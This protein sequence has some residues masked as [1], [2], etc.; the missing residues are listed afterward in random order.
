MPDLCLYFQVHQPYRLRP[1]SFFE[2]RR[3]ANYF[4]DSLNRD[5]MQRVA[6]RCYIP[7]GKSVLQAI[8]A[9]G[10]QLKLT[11]SITGTAIEQMREYAPQALEVFQS[12]VA[13]DCVELLG[14]SYYH[15]LAA[16]CDDT[17]EFCSQVRMHLELMRREF[18]VTPSVFRNTELIFSD[19]IG[20][21]ISQLGFI[22]SFVEG[23]PEVLAGRTPNDVYRA[24]GSDI[25]LLP[26]NCDLSDLIAFRF[27]NGGKDGGQ[28]TAADISKGLSSAVED[29]Q[30]VFVCL[31][32]ET[33]GEHHQDSDRGRAGVCN[34]IEQLAAEL[35]RDSRWRFVTPSQIIKERTPKSELHFPNPRSWA[36]SSRDLSPWQGNQIQKRAFERIY[37]GAVAKRFPIET[38]RRLQTSDHFYYMSNKG[39]PDGEV[40]SYFRP[41]ESPYDAFV[42]YMN[43][44]RG[45]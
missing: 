21:L 5:I 39:G 3:E 19:R 27:R 2:V 41:F 26:R 8:A 10:K 31:D 15:S 6:A 34:L 43:V 24:A 29:D 16:L 11:F 23:I 37:S 4:N 36:D 33:L 38:W 22:G 44:V 13:T 40:H 28:L 14:E 18:N 1:F 42:A 17:G 32:Y 30:V 25:S 7:T 45:S 12:L 9:Y 35:L 20:E